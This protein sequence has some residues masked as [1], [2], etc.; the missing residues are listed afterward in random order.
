M[1][2]N[3]KDL[4]QSLKKMTVKEDDLIDLETDNDKSL[5]TLPT[6]QSQNTAGKET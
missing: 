2:D 4:A 6:S 1:S 5:P 3:P